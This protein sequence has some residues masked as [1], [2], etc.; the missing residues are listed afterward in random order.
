M[1]S[2]TSHI[3]LV[4]KARQQERG[5]GC[6]GSK[7]VNNELN[8]FCFYWIFVAN[9]LSNYRFISSR[10]RAQFKVHWCKWVVDR[11][12]IPKLSIFLQNI[13]RV[14]WTSSTKAEW[15]RRNIQTRLQ[16]HW[17]VSVCVI[18]F[19]MEILSIFGILTGALCW[20][21]RAPVPSVEYVGI[22]W[23]C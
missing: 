17:W 13:S 21:P 7:P 12:L 19:Y 1:H 3:L 9:S 5:D 20:I 23:Q 11:F 15:L 2:F 18:I 10:A 8:W 16:Q 22:Q 4:T 14:C 6:S